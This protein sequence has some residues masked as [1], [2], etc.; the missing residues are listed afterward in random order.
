MAKWVRGGGAIAIT[1][2]GPQ[3][4]ARRMGEGPFVLGRIT[5]APIF[6]LGLACTPAVRLDTWDRMFLPT[7]FGRGAMVWDGPFHVSGEDDSAATVVDWQARLDAVTLR[8]EALVREPGAAAYRAA[9]TALHPVAPAPAPPPGARRQGGSR[10][11]G[12]RSAAPRRPVPRSAGR[13]STAPAWAKPV[14]APAGGASEAGAARTELLVT[15]GTTTSAELLGPPPAAGAVHQFTPIDTPA[16]ARRF[17][18]TGGRILA[19]F[20]ES[21]LWPNLIRGAR[22]RGREAGPGLRP[23]CRRAVRGAGAGRRG[24][25]RRAGRL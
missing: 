18:T 14:A 23:G 19:V 10:P 21:E 13:G 24:G 9:T 2:D 15:S 7:P 3:G 1:P 12:E 17:L 16:T 5:R 11:L 8:A 25:P 4:P 22:A 20:A 6:L